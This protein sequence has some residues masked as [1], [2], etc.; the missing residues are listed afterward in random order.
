M[1]DLDTESEQNEPYNRQNVIK[2]TFGVCVDSGRK[3]I[4]FRSTRYPII[5]TGHH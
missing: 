2:K 1:R 5:E 4:P 3:K